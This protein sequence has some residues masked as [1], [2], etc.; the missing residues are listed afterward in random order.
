[1]QNSGSSV[2]YSTIE[3]QVHIGQLR[4]NEHVRPVIINDDDDDDGDGCRLVAPKH[5]VFGCKLDIKYNIS[6]HCR[7][8]L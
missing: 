5:F 3:S 1:M 4:L 8:R 2:A 7:G 6:D